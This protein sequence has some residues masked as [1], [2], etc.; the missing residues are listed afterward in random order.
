MTLYH[1]EL[2]DLEQSKSYVDFKIGVNKVQ[3][4]AE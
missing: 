3:L 1:K 4:L 2:P